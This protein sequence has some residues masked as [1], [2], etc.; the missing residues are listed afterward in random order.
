MLP[1]R[2]IAFIG[3]VTLTLEYCSRSGALYIPTPNP[4]RA[5]AEMDMLV[6][7]FIDDGAFPGAALVVGHQGT[8]Y[9][10]S[11]Y[12]TYTYESDRAITAQSVFDMAS[13]TKV[14]ATTT[15][16][17][18]LY[19]RG[20]LDLDA[21]VQSYLPAFD[22]PD[23]A[24]IT[25]RQLLT[26][27]SG[28]TP[29]RT[30]YADGV[31]T[32]DAVI[33]AIFTIPLDSPP[34]EEYRYSDFSMITLALVIEAITGQD[35]AA[36]AEEN[37]FTPLG[38]TATG[39]KGT[40]VP[41]PSVVPTEVDDYFRHRL[42]QGEVHDENA[43]L[44]GG[45]AGHAGLFSS[46]LDVARFA[47]MMA[48]QGMYEE[49]Q[50]LRPETVEYFTA[51][52]D[53]SL[54]SRAL[55]WDTKSHDRPSSAGHYF[56]ARTFGHTG[57]TGTSLWIDPDAQIYVILLTNRVYPTRDNSLLQELRP[58]IAD[59]AYEALVGIPRR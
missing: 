8:I 32:R 21:T 49:E 30:F 55:G 57:F 24:D 2:Y 3:L 7:R 46:A 22:S 9:K 35:F 47:G 39:F 37:I 16:A 27:T 5:F 20:S 14:I 18:L 41:D 13:L 45:T 11:S 33:D 38:M 59:L 51:V 56:G 44:L 19:D 42:I 17:M 4:S 12:G 36:Y 10:I 26:H 43:W 29:F 28:F 1:F 48:H 6:D 25:V 31:L 50:F 15:A 58:Q 40:G 54:S 34:G 23:K 53:T 52:V